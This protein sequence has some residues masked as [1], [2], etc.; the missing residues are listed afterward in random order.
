MKT[1]LQICILLL[2]ISCTKQPNL[3]ANIA[4]AYTIPAI[5]TDIEQKNDAIEWTYVM[6]NDS[7]KLQYSKVA[8]K[9]FESW[10]KKMSIE[11]ILPPDLAWSNFISLKEYNYS[12]PDFTSEV[13]QDMFYQLYAYFLQQINP[14]KYNKERL[15]LFT[16]YRDINFLKSYFQYGGTYFGHMHDRIYAYTEYSVYMLDKEL[17]AQT[18]IVKAK[19]KFLMGLK[20]LYSDKLMDDGNTLEKS[21]PKRHDKMIQI[22]DHIDT[23]INNAYLLKETEQFYRD[24]YNYWL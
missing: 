1:L 17:N 19:A 10:F 2:F 9:G 11:K 24:H 3:S 15:A 23:Q 21:K 8:Y 4:E 6:L 7:V 20:K 16:A 5:T 22:I 13:G 14:E 12:R 18:N